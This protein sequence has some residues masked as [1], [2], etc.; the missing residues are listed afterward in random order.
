M[1][2]PVAGTKKLLPT[3]DSS[4]NNLCSQITHKLFTNSQNILLV[5]PGQEL[6]R[7]VDIRRA[8]VLPGEFKRR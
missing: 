3:L 8:L 5:E 2:S 7:P 1:N 6:L 4:L